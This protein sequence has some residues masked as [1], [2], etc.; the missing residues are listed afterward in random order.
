[1]TLQLE[2]VS[3][4]RNTAANKVVLL[5]WYTKQE[6]LSPT[7]NLGKTASYNLNFMRSLHG[8]AKSVSCCKNTQ[9]G[10][11][12]WGKLPSKA[13]QF[14]E[15][16]INPVQIQTVLYFTQI[17]LTSLAGVRILHHMHSVVE[18]AYVCAN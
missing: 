17:D 6:V 15:F 4:D 1:M 14:S 18:P 13:I 16:F 10:E 2:N 8:Q 12:L 5:Y 9:E 11:I 3:P 7:G